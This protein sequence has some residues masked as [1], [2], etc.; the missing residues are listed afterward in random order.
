MIIQGTNNPIRIIFEDIN[1]MPSSIVVTLSN[2]IQVLRKWLTPEMEIDYEGHEIT[3]P[4]TQEESAEWE[5]GHCR[6]EV[7]ILDEYN[8]TVFAVANDEII[9]WSANTVLEN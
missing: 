8:N 6:I 1:D 3:I 5:P 7:K 9:P 4:I 2:E